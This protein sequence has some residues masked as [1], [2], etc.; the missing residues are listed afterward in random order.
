MHSQEAKQDLKLNEQRLLKFQDLHIDV[1]EAYERYHNGK[2]EHH[3]Q[4]TVIA[5]QNI[6]DNENRLE[7]LKTALPTEKEFYELVNLHLL[8]LLQQDDIMTLDAICNEL[9][10]NLRAGNDSVSV[11]KLNPPYNLLVD[12]DKVSLG[13]GDR[14]W[15]YDLAVP[16]RARYQLRHAPIYWPM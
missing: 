16:N 8:D 7:Q 5:E 11:I 1:R 12:L 15:T 14:T 10:T 13:R 9:V 6:E 3:E 4:L 2:I